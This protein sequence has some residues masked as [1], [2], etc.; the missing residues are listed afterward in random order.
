[1]QADL[2][3]LSINP[4][5]TPIG[6]LLDQVLNQTDISIIR[7]VLTFKRNNGKF[8]SAMEILEE[9]AKTSKLKKTQLYER[10]TRLSNR[11]FI[12][13]RLLPRP[14]RYQVNA[15]TIHAGI[16]KWME[17]QKSSIELLASELQSIQCFLKQVDTIRLAAEVN[18]RLS[19]EST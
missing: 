2:T 6:C 10:L 8:P 18:S 5:E 4:D 1:V 17:E 12:S 3:I 14:R 9:L 19:I 11:R 16:R 13:I 15:D 7:A